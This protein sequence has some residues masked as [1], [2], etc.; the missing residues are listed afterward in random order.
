MRHEADPGE[1]LRATLAGPHADYEALIAPDARLSTFMRPKGYVGPEGA[2]QY[3][4]D[5][6]KQRLEI[7]LRVDSVVTSGPRAIAFGELHT[8]GS[9]EGLH[10]VAWGCCVENGL[11]AELCA[12]TDRKEAQDWLKG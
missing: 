3:W 9:V 7:S 11:I 5:A 8:T 6:E 2:R 4:R 10:R 1:L 12:F